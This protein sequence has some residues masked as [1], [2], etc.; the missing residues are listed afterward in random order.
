MKVL[1]LPRED[2]NPYQELLYGEMRRRGVQ[3]I[4]VGK[5]TPSHTLNLLLLPLELAAR[6]L[7]GAHLVH[8]HWVYAFGLPGG[9]RSSVLRRLA[10]TWFIAFLIIVRMLGMRLVWTVHNV[11]PHIPVLHDDVQGRR[12]LV[13]ACDLVLAHSASA[14]SELAGLGI[15]PRKTAVVPHGPLVPP[16]PAEALRTPGTGDRPRRLL[17][18]G[19][20]REYKGVDDLL[21]AFTVLPVDLT[22][23]L[24]VA[25]ECDE[26]SLQSA[27]HALAQQSKDRVTLR[28]ERIP[29]AEVTR[30]LADAD[31]V[32]LPF[33]RVT[34]SGSAMLALC[35]GRPLIVPDL[36]VFADL[37]DRAAVRYDGTMSGLVASLLEVI[38]A[39]GE[40]MA[41]MSHAARFY[42]STT[43]WQQ[44]AERTLSEM[45]SVLRDEPCVGPG[46]VGRSPLE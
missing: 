15:V 12:Q 35:H 11:L 37:P 44:I 38:H 6:R 10:Q 23:H 30:L 32:V 29:D 20:I 8:L 14:L 13:E 18:F 22:V 1:V 34:T 5:L 21:A 36:P 24:T 25:G 16:L 46:S 45:I 41:A 4:Y 28:L 33:R 27:L 42:G 7:G 40:T 2:S 26:P 31:A 3:I 39:D 17:F 9:R 19:K 43:T